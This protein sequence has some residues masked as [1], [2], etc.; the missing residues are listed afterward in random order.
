MKG[1]VYSCL[2]HIHIPFKILL[3]PVFSFFVCF[4]CSSIFVLLLY[5]KKCIFLFSKIIMSK[6]SVL[7]PPSGHICRVIP[8]FMAQARFLPSLLYRDCSTQVAC[9]GSFAVRLD[10]T[11]H[12]LLT[13][14]INCLLPNKLNHESS[15]G[16]RRSFHNDLCI[17]HLCIHFE[18]I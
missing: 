9:N 2:V 10:D 3:R 8:T 1:N 15:E 6:E 5:G 13:N 7:D 18:C 14:D 17:D 12:E 16:T 11:V 4:S